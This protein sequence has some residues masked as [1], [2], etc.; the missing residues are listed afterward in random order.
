MK[1]ALGLLALLLLCGG[2]AISTPNGRRYA[3]E[4]LPMSLHYSVSAASGAP[5]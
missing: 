1:R 4:V 3:V 2:C 5:P